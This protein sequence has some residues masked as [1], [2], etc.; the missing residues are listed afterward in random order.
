MCR[1]YLSSFMA[2][3][4]LQ[5][6]SIW[7]GVEWYACRGIVGAVSYIRKRIASPLFHTNGIAPCHVILNRPN[8][9]PSHR[10]SC[11]SSSMS[12]CAASWNTPRWSCHYPAPN[13][14]QENVSSRLVWGAVTS[15]LATLKVLQRF[16][17]ATSDKP[18]PFCH[19]LPDTSAAGT[20]ADQNSN[21]G[22]CWVV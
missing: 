4:Q 18:H 10:M 8:L 19:F 3:R 15:L 12:L 1:N 7:T 22:S 14:P 13:H 17:L 20:Y 11:V 6:Q 2:L 16:I 5:A 9:S 21:E